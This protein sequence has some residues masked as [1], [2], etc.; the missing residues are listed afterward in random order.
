MK[1]PSYP[2]PVKQAW[3]LRGWSF[4][5]V[6]ATLWVFSQLSCYID[7][8]SVDQLPKQLSEE[9]L[10]ELHRSRPAGYVRCQLD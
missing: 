1:V 10:F 3:V 4:Y 5:I 9:L 8:G 2:I 6:C 7:M